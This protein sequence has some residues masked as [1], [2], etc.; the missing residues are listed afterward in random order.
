MFLLLDQGAGQQE[1]RLG[2]P[3]G[4]RVL[5]QDRGRGGFGGRK[6]FVE[7]EGRG[8][9]VS[10]PGVALEARELGG[11]LFVFAGLEVLFGFGERLGGKD[12]REDQEE[13]EDTERRRVHDGGW[14]EPT[15]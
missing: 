6:L 9:Q 3:L 2:S 1:S 14:D 5:V 4:I 7:K 15:G 12:G 13:G 10:G 11:G 8:M